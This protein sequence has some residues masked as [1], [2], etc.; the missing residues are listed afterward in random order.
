M[1]KL[2]QFL[3]FL[4]PFVVESALVRNNIHILRKKILGHNIYDR[5]V[6]PDGKVEV[7]FGIDFVDMDF[8]PHKHMLKSSVYEKMMWTDNRLVWD[9]DDF[10]GIDRI[11]VNADEIWKPDITLYNAIEAP[12]MMY[13][14]VEEPINV[15]ILSSGMVIFTPA[16]EY[17]SHCNV[18]FN[19]W[20]WGEQNCTM[21]FGSW[22][23]D[24]ANVNV[25]GFSLGNSGDTTITVDN[26]KG[27][28]F[29]IAGTN[30][31]RQE[32]EYDADPGKAYPRMDLSI[33]FTQKVVYKN[34]QPDFN[35]AFPQ[36]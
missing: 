29:E 27:S 6:K 10:D 36:I 20:P 35:P 15:V 13:S 31:F 22:T 4:L 17:K 2:L 5:H 28:K 21:I 18:N 25:K 1:N 14:H 19:D 33:K 16:M 11:Q 30:Y 24:M 34:N 23:Y 26:F 32:K 8:C 3:L 12:K 9:K 7:N